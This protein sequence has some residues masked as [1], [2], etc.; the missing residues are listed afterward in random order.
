[1]GLFSFFNKIIKRLK[2]KQGL[3]T[4]SEINCRNRDIVH[5]NLDGL[6]MYLERCLAYDKPHEITAVIPRAELRK[7]ISKGDQTVE[8]I[9]VILNSITIVS[10]PFRPSHEG[11]GG[12]PVIPS[13]GE[14]P[15]AESVSGK[16]KPYITV[17]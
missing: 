7:K 8:E 4:Q 1:M 16:N 13:G 14:Q 15:A 10:A 17:N 5:I 3:K 11:Q 12:E 9:E 6:D 2:N